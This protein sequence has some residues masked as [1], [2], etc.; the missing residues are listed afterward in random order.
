M[1]QTGI[2][3]AIISKKN[4]KHS[5]FLTYGMNNLDIEE[6]TV[7]IGKMI[8]LIKM[9]LFELLC[10]M[11]RNLVDETTVTRPPDDIPPATCIAE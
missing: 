9:F 5:D 1:A 11:H 10:H 7:F 4:D 3:G 2:N 6:N 8:D